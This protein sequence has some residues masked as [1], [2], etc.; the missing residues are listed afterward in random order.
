HHAVGADL[1]NVT[2][3]FYDGD[4]EQGG[5]LFDMEQIPHI[6]AN[7]S[8][9]TR[10]PYHTEVCGA[11]QLFVQAIPMDGEAPMTTDVNAVT[12][13]CPAPSFSITKFQGKAE[14]VGSGTNNGKLQV[15]GKVV[16]VSG[17]DL[18]TI[19]LRLLDLLRESAG[20]GELVR[21]S[22]GAL[23]PLQLT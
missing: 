1:D 12:V 17:L 4:P 6:E 3:L 23:L 11:H 18:S 2:V 13:E 22:F 14:K 10:V 15:S 9:V 7:E 19:T 21:D 8:F 5:K 20:A 16:G